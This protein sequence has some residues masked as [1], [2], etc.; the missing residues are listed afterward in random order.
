MQGGPSGV[1]HGGGR[2]RLNGR[3]AATA[4][5]PA[6]PGRRGFDET[7]ERAGAS[8]LPCPSDG[9]R[10]RYRLNRTS[11]TTVRRR[12]SPKMCCWILWL[13]RFV[14]FNSVVIAPPLHLTPKL[15]FTMV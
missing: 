1:P 5:R 10:R 12:M 9:E 3:W 11:P 8:P 2:G 7:L 6:A 4:A 13:K 14:T 15:P